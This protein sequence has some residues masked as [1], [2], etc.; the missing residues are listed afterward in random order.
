MLF[1]FPFCFIFFLHYK[2]YSY[3]IFN[4]FW[5]LDFDFLKKVFLL[6]IDANKISQVLSTKVD[7]EFVSDINEAVQSANKLAVPGDLILL[8][9]ACSSLD[10]YQ[11]FK[12]RGD[13]FT[14]AVN[15]L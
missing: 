14:A 15:A 3:K 10:M 2:L 1:I 6:G 12:E 5:R 11:N 8:A 4:R 13:A 9:P 7:Q